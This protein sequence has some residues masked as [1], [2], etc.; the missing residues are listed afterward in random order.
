MKGD[1]S[2][3][4]CAEKDGKTSSC[5]QG[6]Y[7]CQC[8]YRP[9]EQCCGIAPNGFICGANETCCGSVE[10]KNNKCCPSGTTCDSTGECVPDEQCDVVALESVCNDYAGEKC[11]NSTNV[12]VKG[13]HVS[14][15]CPQLQSQTVSYPLPL[16][17][18]IYLSIDIY[19]YL[20]LPSFGEP[21]FSLFLPFNHIYVSI[22]F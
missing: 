10:G 20:A 21:L 16:A 7:G 13:Y 22:P 15:C 18:S 1:H 19:I 11:C 3:R 12:C 9:D 8:M 2:T 17:L 14:S 6:I 4:C 5:C